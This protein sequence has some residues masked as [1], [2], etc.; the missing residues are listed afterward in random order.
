MLAL[1]ATPDHGRA[2]HRQR[3]A[4]VLLAAGA[5]AGLTLLLPAP[6]SA[7]MPNCDDVNRQEA[8]RISIDVSFPDTNLGGCAF[9]V[10]VTL[11]IS[12]TYRPQF[13]ADDSGNLTSEAANIRTRATIINPAT[14]RFFTDGGASL[15]TKTYRPDGSLAEVR[16]TGLLHNVRLDTGE[17][18]FHQSGINLVFFG[19][20]GD[21]LYDITHGNF[22]SEDAF[23]SAICPLLA[24]PA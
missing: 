24:Q 5:L 23:L 10:D 11:A 16:F 14:G 12:G 18:L 17:R 15:E 2:T 19:P 20:D 6:A 13:A 22:Q 1:P 21:F 3:S 7:A 9:P 4:F 8:C